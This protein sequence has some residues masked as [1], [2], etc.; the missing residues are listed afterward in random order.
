MKIAVFVSGNGS[1]LQALIEASGRGELGDGAVISMVVCDKPGAFAL[2]RAGKA[3]I[4]TFVAEPAGEETREEYDRK[5]L[6]VLREEKIGLVVL[7]GFMRIL[8]EGFVKEYGG[9]MINIHPSLLPAFRGTGGIKEAFDYGVK[10]T[11]VTVH[12]VENELDA[13]P[14]IMQEPVRVEET[15][16]MESLE[17]KIHRQEHRMYPEAVR[18]FV[19]G[20]IRLEG[21]K[22]EIIK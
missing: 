6:A 15:D 13:G 14:V 7:A 12:F 16:T 21:R 9:R 11:G 19:E 18:L 10:V 2:E 5:I 1:N 20:R 8:S 4:R 17:E 3:G 22:V